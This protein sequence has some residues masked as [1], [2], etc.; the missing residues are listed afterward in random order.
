VTDAATLR[1]I[2]ESSLGRHMKVCGL[3]AMTQA[4][5]G[6]AERLDQ[7]V[8]GGLTCNVLATDISHSMN[9]P[10]GSGLRKKILVMRDAVADLL[11]WYADRFAGRLMA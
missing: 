9:E 10:A 7:R 3:K 4:F 1:R 8:R 11:K 2:A 5:R 6:I